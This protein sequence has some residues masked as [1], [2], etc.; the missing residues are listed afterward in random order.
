MAFECDNNLK[1]DN[2][3]MKTTCKKKLDNRN[4]FESK[5]FKWKTSYFN[6]ETLNMNIK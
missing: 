1:Q 5:T 3:Q 2:I 6:I 4:P